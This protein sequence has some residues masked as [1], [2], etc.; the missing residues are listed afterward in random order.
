[1]F[2]WIVLLILIIGQFMPIL[3]M[4]SYQMWKREKKNGNILNFAT[5]INKSYKCDLY[6]LGEPYNLNGKH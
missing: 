4:T 6:H 1:M 3:M 5:I 2:M